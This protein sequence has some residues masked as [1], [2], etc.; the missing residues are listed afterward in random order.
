MIIVALDTIAVFHRHRIQ[1]QA[2]HH[3]IVNRLKSYCE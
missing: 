3:Y 2:E 1:H